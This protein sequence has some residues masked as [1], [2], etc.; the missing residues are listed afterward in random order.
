MPTGGSETIFPA[1]ASPGL[2]LPC[3]RAAAAAATGGRIEVLPFLWTWP[4]PPDYIAFIAK[5]RRER[6]TMRSLRLALPALVLAAPMAQAAPITWAANGHAY[7]L[8]FD[9][10]RGWEAARLAAIAR[11]GQLVAITSAAEQE[12]IRANLFPA[13]DDQGFVGSFWIGLTDAVTEGAF[14]W[15]TGETFAYANWGAGQPDNNDAFAQS[16][17]GDPAARE[18]W[19]QLVW[20]LDRPL[21]QRGGWNDAPQQGYS[22]VSGAAHLDRRGYIVEYAV[23]A[24]AALPLMLGALGLFGLLRLRTRS[25]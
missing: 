16:A 21:A 2:A 18:D 9:T 17:T 14:R 7:E 13:A 4:R 11:G 20:R 8:V 25:H 12:F 23:P 19:A 1:D 15:V 6:P 5:L 24:P 10:T 3:W 22:G